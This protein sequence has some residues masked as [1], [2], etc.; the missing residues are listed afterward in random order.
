MRRNT[1][2]AVSSGDAIGT[3]S[4]AYAAAEPNRRSNGSSSMAGDQSGF[5]AVSTMSYGCSGSNSSGNPRRQRCA[6]NKSPSTAATDSWTL[7][8]SF[9]TIVGVFTPLFSE[10][11]VRHCQRTAEQKVLAEDLRS[12]PLSVFCADESA[13][14]SWRSQ[15]MRPSLVRRRS[16]SQRSLVRRRIVESTRTVSLLIP[17]LRWLHHKRSRDR[18]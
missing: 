4:V 13:A 11:L 9:T 8:T 5:S 3:F 1:E 6:L 17:N 15:R 10:T 12:A 7:P 16:T 14:P 18:L 2:S